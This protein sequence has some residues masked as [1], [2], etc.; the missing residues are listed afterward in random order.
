M[1]N[2]LM[3]RSSSLI[4]AALVAVPGA[5]CAQQLRGT[6]HELGGGAPLPGAVVTAVD[7]AGANSRR[8]I[9]DAQGRFSIVLPLHADH[10][11]VVRI[12]YRPRNVAVTVKLETSIDIAMERIPPMLEAVKVSDK[13]LCPGSI[14]RGAA[15]ALWE[16][17]RDGLLAAV[18][19]RE[20]KPAMMRTIIFDRRLDARD[21]LV[22]EQ[23]T[24][25]QTGSSTRPF[26][27][28]AGASYFATAG[29]MSDEGAD[30]RVFHA[31]D[32]DVLLD[33]AFAA[34]HCF[35]L[36]PADREHA[37][38]I[39][40][41]FVPVPGAAR[42]TI[43]EVAGVIWID[44]TMPQLRT[45]DFQ[46]TGLEP[47]AEKMHAGG[48]LEF[49]MMAN[50]V[51]FIEHW[52]LR[53]PILTSG[54]DHSYH[55][56]RPATVRRQ[57]RDDL[58]VL[59]ISEAG[60]AVLDATWADGEAWH[61]PPTIVA[62]DVL[63]RDSRLPIA[64]AVVS[65]AGTPDSATTDS[66]GHFQLDVIPGKYT[67]VAADTL[68]REFVADRTESRVVT[69][70]RG[71]T[72]NVRIEVDR[73]ANV[74]SDVCHG[75]DNGQ[76]MDDKHVIVVGHTSVPDGALPHESHVVAE[77]QDDYLL[78]SEAMRINGKRQETPIDDQGRFVV[79][80]IVRERPIHLRLYFGRTDVVAD[81]SITIYHERLT[82]VLPWRVNGSIVA[83][84]G[85][86]TGTVVGTDRR[87]LSGATVVLTEPQRS[88]T[89]DS[90][91]QFQIAAVKPGTYSIEIRRVGYTP[92]ADS[93][94]LAARTQVVR[95]FMLRPGATLDTVRALAARSLH[96][97]PDLREFEQRSRTGQGTFIVDS[98]LRRHETERVS[99]VLREL[100]PEVQI[101][102]S[103][104]TAYVVSA[105]DGRPGKRALEMSGGANRCFAT[106][107][108]DGL[109]LYDLS[110]SGP[111]DTPPNIND[112]RVSEL[113]GVEYH[114]ADG[115]MPARFRSS[116]CGTLL[117]WT[118]ER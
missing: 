75:Q 41:A 24:E 82:H 35:H 30:G 31:P 10:L 46:Y 117:L 63:Q 22:R 111:A 2:A 47:A 55:P 81:T 58:T 26:L 109:L 29:Y 97:A 45:F 88:A 69:A 9:A 52:W 80:G 66:A 57:D 78:S 94:T 87:P 60:G 48:H 76:E 44:Q 93:V 74:V 5:L 118:R 95:G 116:P 71:K 23:H 16:Q 67:L 27:A 114:P 89:T 107:Y 100:I 15:F 36:Q 49:R 84:G 91:G 59:A 73:V 110:T 51:S 86:F 68:L 99:D 21:A 108:L 96:V 98:L 113:A 90:A 11:H 92:I 33:P 32:A 20:L 37:G 13:E 18:V 14:E 8:A 3:G 115:P 112:F 25:T 12:G 38:Q 4:A 34:R 39:G 28:S 65:L 7:S 106:V 1:L 19:A 77:W 85:R 40:L 56:N 64:H 53:L 70:E 101:Q 102:S 42:D 104:S 61:A 79:C 6:V 103:G 17:A 83:G 54:P 50:G 72:T 62:G 43:V 105:R